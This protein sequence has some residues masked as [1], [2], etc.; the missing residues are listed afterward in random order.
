[1]QNITAKI[2]WITVAILGLSVVFFFLPY[3]TI[4]GES[5]NPIALLQYISD[6]RGQI[7]DDATFEVTF[8]FIVPFALTALTSIIMVFKIGTKKCILSTILNILAVVVYTLFFSVTFLDINSENIGF[9]LVGNI[10]ISCLGIIL[11][12]VV[13]VLNKKKKA[14]TLPQRSFGYSVSIRVMRLKGK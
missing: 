1:M 2:K 11:P 4:Y 10:V 8:G 13:L 6:N 14:E 12:I 7:R 3:V 5:S 9:G